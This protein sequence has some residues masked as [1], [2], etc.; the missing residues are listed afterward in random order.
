MNSKPL[1]NLFL[2]SLGLLLG[3]LISS[4]A[5]AEIYKTTLPDG[6]VVY[7]DSA[8]QNAQKLELEP[9]NQLPAQ[10]LPEKKKAASGEPSDEED[11]PVVYSYIKITSPQDDQAMEGLTGN[12]S[13]SLKTKPA[14]APGDR[15]TLYLDG[16]KYKTASQTSFSLSNLAHGTH[17]ISAKIR[18][19][20]GK[21]LKSSKSIRFHTFRHN[22]TQQRRGR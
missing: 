11:K 7:S 17:Q 9:I 21:T 3:G 18:N 6:S 10:K 4:T 13:V 16:K 8:S 2:K 14:L 22:V 5:T 1:N 20:Q 12:V 15:I 19:A